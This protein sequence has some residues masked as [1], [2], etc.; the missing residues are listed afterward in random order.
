MA[1]S[2]HSESRAVVTNPDAPT[3]DSLGTG[4]TVAVLG[5]AGRQVAVPERVGGFE[6]NDTQDPQTTAWRRVWGTPT[7][8]GDGNPANY[9]YIQ[10]SVYICR[11]KGDEEQWTVRRRTSHRGWSERLPANVPHPPEG[12]HPVHGATT[13]DT[14]ASHLPSLTS[15]LETAVDVMQATSAIAPPIPPVATTAV[16]AN[17]YGDR[18][19]RATTT[20]EYLAYHGQQPGA[21]MS[22]VADLG[23]I[24]DVARVDAVQSNTPEDCSVPT[25][26]NSEPSDLEGGA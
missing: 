16:H 4:E 11:E 12:G 26:A 25:P 10:T 21:A 9:P 7:P 23:A 1:R 24:H 22:N 15:A 3:A 8:Q 2:D 13:S 17:R 20:L 18:T 5:P 6:H 14:L 19:V